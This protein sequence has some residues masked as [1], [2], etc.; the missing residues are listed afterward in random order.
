MRKILLTY[1]LVMVTFL[2]ACNNDG[3]KGSG[4]ALVKTTNPAPLSFER[5][6]K[7]EMDLVKSIEQDVEGF[8]ELYDVSVLK[9]EKDILVAYKVRHLHRY[10]MKDIEKRMNKKLEEKY[11]DENFIVSS[12][13]KI[14]LE[15]VELEDNLKDPNFSQEKAEKKLQEIIKMKK[16]L[17]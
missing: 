4:I 14:F 7:K 11:P 12:D 9:G 10:H 1:F 5:N 6:T 8:K 2:C 17:T 3:P 13:Y 15:A 16:E